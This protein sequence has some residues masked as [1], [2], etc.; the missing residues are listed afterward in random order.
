MAE[1]I[2]EG[3][4]TEAPGAWSF[5][6]PSVIYQSTHAAGQP[7]T[8]GPAFYLSAGSTIADTFW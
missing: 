4:W 1:R 8:V 7:T 2:D 5:E 3:E 6:N